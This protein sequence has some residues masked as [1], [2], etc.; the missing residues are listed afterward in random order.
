MQGGCYEVSREEEVLDGSA[1]AAGR[2]N[3]EQQSA[4]AGGGGGFE[5]RGGAPQDSA[6]S[7]QRL[8]GN[9]CHVHQQ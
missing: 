5:V 9:T 2:A 4:A 7:A 6:A 8:P 3:D 1:G